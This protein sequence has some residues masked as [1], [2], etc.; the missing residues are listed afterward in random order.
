MVGTEIVDKMNY[1]IIELKRRQSK[2]NDMHGDY[3]SGMS[4]AYGE[5]IELA[6]KKA[7]EG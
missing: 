7:V 1:L 5:I 6:K 4:D 2:Y 3:Y